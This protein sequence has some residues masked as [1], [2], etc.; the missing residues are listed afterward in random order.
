MRAT[1]A[2]HELMITEYR[3]RLA[4]AER[5][6]RHRRRTP[7]DDRHAMECRSV[8]ALL[9]AGTTKPRRF[10]VP[11][12]LTVRCAGRGHVLALA[13]A[14]QPLPV[15]VP[16]VTVRRDTADGLRDPWLLARPGADVMDDFYD[17]GALFYDEDSPVTASD[18]TVLGEHHRERRIDDDGVEHPVGIYLHCRCGSSWVLPH[19][20]MD[21][22]D[23][24]SDVLTADA[25]R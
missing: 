14:T 9:S 23:R 19:V 7:Y 8:I 11:V 18:L 10:A 12:R 22:L 3:E 4:V 24:K 16:E 13:Y 1:L 5:A 2:D 25:L 21:T 6:L 15:L 17:E 20:L